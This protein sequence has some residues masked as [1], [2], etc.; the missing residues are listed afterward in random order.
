MGKSRS[1]QS[2]IQ[3]SQWPT[4]KVHLGWITQSTRDGYV[5]HSLLGSFLW[6]IRLATA[7]DRV[8]GQLGLSPILHAS[9]CAYGTNDFSDACQC[10]AFASSP[11]GRCFNHT[12]K[13]R[14]TVIL[15]L[16]PL[17][18]EDY[19]TELLLSRMYFVW[20]ESISNRIVLSPNFPLVY[21]F[22]LCGELMI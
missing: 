1:S 14:G 7:R 20:N 2:R 11:N 16:C 3:P 17:G 5:H 4:R 12:H 10:I 13:K 6:S 8:L 19:M 22:S 21:Q 9:S 15:G 18:W